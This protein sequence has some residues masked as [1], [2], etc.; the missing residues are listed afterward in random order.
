[1]MQPYTRAEV[2]AAQNSLPTRGQQCQHC[3]AFIP[4]FEDLTPEQA[5]QI[6]DMI[7]RGPINAIKALRDQT[8]CSM[9]WAKLWVDHGGVARG[10]FFNTVP[11][12]YCE[13]PL[14]S[15]RA[16]QCR[17]CHR[18]WHDSENV[19]KLSS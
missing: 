5:D 11:C 12:P 17:H 2:Q 16:K 1:M 3:G 10:E 9:T 7:S 18:D 8:G 4:T 13:R 19:K 6:R 14:R 15:A